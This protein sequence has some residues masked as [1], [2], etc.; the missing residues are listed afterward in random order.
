T[1]RLDGARAS[2]R[3]LFISSIPLFVAALCMRFTDGMDLFIVK[4]LTDEQTAGWYAGAVNLALVPAFLGMALMPVILSGVAEQRKRLGMAAAGVAGAA[5]L[6]LGLMLL[7]FAAIGI[8]LSSEL[9]F[10]ILGPEFARTAD[11]LSLLLMASA[12][13]VWLTLATAFLA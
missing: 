12:G 2:T 3:A 1:L 6:R 10:M 11:F 9:T 13:R 7:P 4:M 8:V 5:W